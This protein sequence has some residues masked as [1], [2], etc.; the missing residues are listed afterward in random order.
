MTM[1]NLV[2]IGLLALSIG[3]FVPG[4]SGCGDKGKTPVEKTDTVKAGDDTAKAKP[5]E[6]KVKVDTTAKKDT[7]KKK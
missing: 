6:T 1:K 3:I 5:D 7:S 4:C 2:K